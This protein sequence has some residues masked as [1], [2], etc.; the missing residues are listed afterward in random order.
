[1]T[2]TVIKLIYIDLL[3]CAHVKI[4]NIFPLRIFLLCNSRRYFDYNT[5]LCTATLIK[6]RLGFTT[7]RKILHI[8]IMVS[9]QRTFMTCIISSYESKAQVS[10]PDRN[11]YVVRSCCCPI[12]FTFLSSSREPQGK[13]QPK[14]GKSILG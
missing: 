14:M 4:P 2:D 10:F 7:R 6:I 13:F 12:L 5:A 1:M 11:L 9:G 3:F 8:I